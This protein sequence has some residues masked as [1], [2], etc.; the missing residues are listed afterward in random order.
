[1][2]DITPDMGSVNGGD[3]I[4]IKGDKFS[5]NV[6]P[7]EFKCRFTPTTMKIPP[8]HTKASFINVTTISCPSPGGWSEADRMIL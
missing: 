7:N 6:D 8:R 4:Y 2:T 1:M 5:P 3:T